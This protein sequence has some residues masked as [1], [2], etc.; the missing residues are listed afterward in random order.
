MSSCGPV[1]GA[2][3][4]RVEVKSEAEVGQECR[5]EAARASRRCHS[6][7]GELS[8]DVEL[9]DAFVELT[10]RGC[11]ALQPSTKS[12]RPQLQRHVAS[13]SWRLL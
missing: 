8:G 2:K 7:P 13:S 4:C 1:V 3:R 9:L 12:A 11:R 5:F 6:A 10:C